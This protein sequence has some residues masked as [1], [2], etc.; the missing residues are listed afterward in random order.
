MYYIVKLYTFG[1]VKMTYAID[2]GLVFWKELFVK[3]ICFG[4]IMIYEMDFDFD[5]RFWRMMV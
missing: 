4:F 2:S 5:F 3:D 1:I